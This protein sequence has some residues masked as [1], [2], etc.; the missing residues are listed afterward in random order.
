MTPD[1]TTAAAEA[2]AQAMISDG[3]EP[4]ATGDGF[5]AVA[6]SIST[7]LYGREATARNLYALAIDLSAPASA[8]N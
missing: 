1:Q 2:A 7:R 6:I 4:A 3:H 5:L 8:I